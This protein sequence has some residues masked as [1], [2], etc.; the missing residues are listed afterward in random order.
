[1]K[2]CKYLLLL[3]LLFPPVPCCV[4]AGQKPYIVNFSRDKYCAANKNWSIAQDERGTMYFGNDVG[5]L[6]SDGMEWRLH[7]LPG[8]PLVRALA[9]ESHYTLYTGGDSELGRWDRDAS[10]RLAYTSLNHLLPA[11]SLDGES[12]WRIWVADK[13]VY[14]QSFSHIYIYDQK[15]LQCIG[16]SDGLLFLQK[17]RD[18]YWVQSMHGP[19]HRLRDGK[20]EQVP[21]SEFLEGTLTP[22]I[23]PYGDDRYLLGT[24]SGE[25][26]IYDHRTF[27]P[28]NPALSR[29]LDGKELNCGIYSESRGSYYLGT[30]LE[31]IY[32]VDRQGNVLNHFY[33]GNSLQNNTILALCEDS[34]ANIWVGMD[35]G[36]A[37]LRYTDELSYYRSVDASSGAV[38]AA[39]LWNGNLLVG[40]NQGLFYT[41]DK[42]IGNLELFSSLK[43]IKGTER[44]VWNLQQ[45]DGRLLCCHNSGLLEVRPDLTVRPLYRIHSGI[46]RVLEVTLNHTPL[47][48]LVTYN[49][50][51]I[52]NKK[53]GAVT[54]MRQIPELIY[55]AEID[56]LGNLWLETI[57]R[58]VYKCRLN[59]TLDAFRYYTYYGNEQHKGLPRHLRL[60]KASNRVVFLGDNRFYTYNES[61]DSLQINPLLNRCFSKVD[62][63]KR[64]VPI[65]HE[66]SWA[67]S[68]SS[69]YRFFYDGYIAR[70]N[71]A[72][73][74]E[75]D[76]LALITAYENIAI[77]NDSLSLICLDAG[78]ILH[79]SHRSNQHA[80]PLETPRPEFVHAGSVPD[81]GYASPNS[82]IRIPYSDNTVTVGF[83]VNNAF[84][85]NFFA[86]YKL[87][88]V[89][90]EW[91][92][93]ER[94]SS[95]SYARLPQ[96]NYTLCLRATDG[97]D[98]YSPDVKIDFEIL[99]PWYRTTW[100]YVVCFLLSLLF[101][102]A[103][104]W[105]TKRRLQA[106]HLRRMRAQEAEYLRRM[107]EQLQHEIEEKN[108]EMF[109]QTSFIIRKNELILKLKEQVEEIASKNTQKGLIPL[110]IRLNALLTD[111][112]DAEDDW[113]MFLIRFE[114]KHRTFFKTLKEVYPSLTASD[115][116]LCACLKLNMDTKEIASLMNLSVRAV[117]NSRYRLRK[118]LNLQPTQNLNEFFLDID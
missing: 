26:Y 45:I 4:L 79:N 86:E 57:N 35:R 85:G 18:E 101:L 38:Y 34:Q 93:P 30:L 9:V 29:I 96:G 111:S 76:N 118:K 13:Q 36:L 91:S 56:H 60:F 55:N 24:S 73:K 112:L 46:Y 71:N 95:V 58:G 77:L 113:K 54:A 25:I 100:W 22:V 48:I 32:E 51:S 53:T 62:N 105:L 10:G 44:Q 33:T 20:L 109:T 90:E 50:L 74:V 65:N 23:L 117:E 14:F 12:I 40:T 31:G 87:E 116:R 107:N 99:P 68:P 41:S 8:S 70:I 61:S 72:Y 7:A 19:I 64:I 3:L 106:K 43:L 115:L 82:T 98:N 52:V 2:I 78:F 59:E 69:V 102:S 80:V 66:E 21:G 110:Y 6:E 11:R 75:A 84:A 5:L 28:W 42:Q 92:P 104:L 88:G 81:K 94:R 17:V 15:S 1:M 103:V 49:G 37:Y 83:T 27:L 16:L 89:D 47:E 39:A 108:A 114:Q 63:L 97:L 67:I